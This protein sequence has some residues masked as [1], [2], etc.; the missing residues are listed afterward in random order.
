MPEAR[1]GVMRLFSVMMGPGQHTVPK[2]SRTLLN[3]SLHEAFAVKWLLFS[4]SVS[5]A[6]GDDA[7]PGGQQFH[8][9]GHQVQS[10]LVF[11][12]LVVPGA[13]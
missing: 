9:F 13:S 3:L 12:G 1:R 7:A 6:I 10:C 5:P 4:R 2:G 8:S 11:Q